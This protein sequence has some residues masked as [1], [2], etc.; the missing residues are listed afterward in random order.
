MKALVNFL[1]I[2][3]RHVEKDCNGCP[4]APQ[5]TTGEDCHKYVIHYPENAKERIEQYIKE[6]KS[7]LGDIGNGK[8]REK[9]DDCGQTVIITKKQV[10]YDSYVDEYTYRCPYCHT[11]QTAVM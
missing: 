7:P 11:L 9:C 1:K 2:C 6:I 8:L 10:L 5:S 4:F 3:N